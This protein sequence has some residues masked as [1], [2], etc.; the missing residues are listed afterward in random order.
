[1]V[2]YVCMEGTL[3]CDFQL[4][5]TFCFALK[6]FVLE[7]ENFNIDRKRKSEDLLSKGS[8]QI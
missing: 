5:L 3:H 1:M 7:T 2:I 8:F 6:V 4:T